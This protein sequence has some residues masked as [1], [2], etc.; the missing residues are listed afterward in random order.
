MS[1][2]GGFFHMYTRIGRYS[3]FA[4]IGFV[5][6]SVFFLILAVYD[7]FIVFEVDSIVAFMAAALLLFRDPRA[8]VQ[9]RVLDAM[10][11]SSDQTIQ[12]LSVPVAVGFTYLQK[13]NG[14]EDVV[15][16]PAVSTYYG[17]PSG[18]LASSPPME[19]TPPGR[20]LAELYKREAGLTDVTME[21]I[22][23]SLPEV[24][25]ENFGIAR[26]VEIDSNDGGD[27]VKVLLHGA[28]ATCGCE[29]AEQAQS[30]GKGC[31]GCVVSSFFAVLVSTATKRPVSLQRCLHGISTDEWTVS[32]TLGQSPP[33]SA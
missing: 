31:I 15:V 11:L 10:S 1:N 5:S 8:R 18:P 22:R 9:A 24:M 20:R 12:E 27:G 33:V 21:A 28:S 17:L 6:L 16:V 7:Q 2:D 13:G 23:S 19:I 32:M 26:S 3:R 30:A 25:R 4:G 14:V 29:E